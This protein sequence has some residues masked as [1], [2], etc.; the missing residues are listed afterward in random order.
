MRRFVLGTNRATSAQDSAFLAAVRGTWPGVGW[1]HQL[2]DMWLFA[3][4][5]STMTSIALRDIAKQ[6]FPRVH[7]MVMEIPPGR[8]NWAGF[9]PGYGR[10]G[11]MFTWMRKNWERADRSSP[12]S[13][14]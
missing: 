12:P 13:S 8:T 7:I 11:D 5:S 4:P 2:G 9:G 6:A 3:D 1:W 14:A 10:K